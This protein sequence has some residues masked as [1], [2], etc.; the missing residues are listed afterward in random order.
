VADI[1]LD[2]CVPPE[3]AMVDI[4]NPEKIA[5]GSTA[6]FFLAMALVAD[7]SIMR[8]SSTRIRDEYRLRPGR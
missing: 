8:Q 4:G 6:V 1:A 5:A 2:N 7:A 3:D